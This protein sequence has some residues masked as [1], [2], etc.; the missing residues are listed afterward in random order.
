MKCCEYSPRIRS[1]LSTHNGYSEMTNNLNFAKINLQQRNETGGLYYKSCT[2]II[3]D[4]NDSTI[5]GPVL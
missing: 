1:Y 4:R 5:V 2:I 3:Y